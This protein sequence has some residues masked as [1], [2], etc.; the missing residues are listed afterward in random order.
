M[1]SVWCVLFFSVSN[2][3]MNVKN[4]IQIQYISL[5]SGILQM[6]FLCRWGCFLWYIRYEYR[7]MVQININRIVEIVVI[8][9]N[10][11]IM[12]GLIISIIMLFSRQIQEKV[13]FFVGIV[14]FDSLVNVFGVMFFCVR[15]NSIWLVEKMLL[16]VEDVVEVSMIKLIMFVVVGRFISINS[17]IN[18]FLFGIMEFYGVI[19]IMII[20]VKMQNM[21]IWIGIELIVCGSDFFGFLVFVVVVLISLMFMKVNIVIWKLVKNLL[22]FFG[23]Q[24]LLFY[25]CVKDVL[26]FVGDLKCIVIII[27]LIIINVIMVMILIIVN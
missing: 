5:L 3:S 27:S 4:V 6:D 8:M 22:I 7:M 10:V 17:L 25:R 2:I 21:M 24:L 15:L 20:S 18:G 11:L 19:D 14:C 23:N 9:V 26:M 1:I 13:R 12:F 16:L